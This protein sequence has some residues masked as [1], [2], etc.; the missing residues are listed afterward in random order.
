[1]TRDAAF[2]LKISLKICEINLGVG[3]HDREIEDIIFRY[4]NEIEV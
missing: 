3:K 1:M 2:S 4:R